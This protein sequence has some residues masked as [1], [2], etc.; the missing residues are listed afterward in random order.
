[1]HRLIRI[2]CVLSAA[3]L[4]LGNSNCS[5]NSASDAPQYVTD[6][7]IQD[8]SGNVV[9]TGNTTSAPSFAAGATIE[10]T[11]TVRN[12]STATQTLFFNSSEQSNFAV[13]QQ[14]TADVVWNSDNGVTPDKSAF[15][16]FT[17]TSG[18]TKSVTFSWD[19]KDD[20]GNQLAAGNYEV[21][22]GFTVYNTA[23]A[24]SAAANGDSMAEGQPTAT[25]MFPTVYRSILLS[26]TIQ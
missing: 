11:V 25:Q 5:K 24:G 22:G 3:A 6:I 19:Q 1:M 20:A 26:F 23:G 2:L 21:L 4:L 14:G 10:F 9:S 17:L 13:V 7:E 18:Q 16:S 15:T 8:G 12:R